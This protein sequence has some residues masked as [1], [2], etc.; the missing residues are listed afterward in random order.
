MKMNGPE[1]HYILV[2]AIGST[3]VGFGL[4]IFAIIFGSLLGVCKNTN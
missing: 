3:V 1:W 2:A 4:P